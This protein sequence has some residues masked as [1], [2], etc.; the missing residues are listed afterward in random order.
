MHDL[1]ALA[2]VA[3][4]YLE[5]KRPYDAQALAKKIIDLQ[6]RWVGPNNVQLVSTYELLADIYHVAGETKEEGVVLRK[7]LDVLKGSEG[8]G[9]PATAGIKGRYESLLRG[10]GR[11]ADAKRVAATHVFS[12]VPLPDINYRDRF[13][14]LNV[15]QL[16][17]ESMEEKD[18]TLVSFRHDLAL[19][20]GAC[21]EPNADFLDSLAYGLINQQKY[22]E[23]EKVL[24]E[25]LNIYTAI[26]GR[27]NSHRSICMAELWLYRTLLL[28][29]YVPPPG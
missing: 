26:E 13:K 17:V 1:D 19:K 3:K 27:C 8:A 28:R 10:S 12:P 21:S 6:L 14:Y 7:A 16:N 2:T 18:K 24:L 22:N 4:S 9:S 5:K 20:Y 15:D 11:S 25:R 23:A 29:Q